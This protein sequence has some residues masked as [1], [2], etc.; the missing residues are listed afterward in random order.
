MRAASLVLATLLATHASA[1]VC[2]RPDPPLG[3]FPVTIEPAVEVFLSDNYRTYGTLIVPQASP[4]ACGWPLVVFVHPLGQTRAHEGV[5]QQLV[6]TQ[7]FA[8]WSFDVRGHGQALGVNTTHPNRGSTLW[9]P[10]E[11][12]DLVEQIDFVLGNPDWTGLVDPT[13]I[14]ITGSSQ[15]G[16]Q[17]WSAAAR[18]GQTIQVAG[19]PPR[20]MPAIACVIANDLVADP[21]DDW[22][23]DGVLFSTFFTNVIAGAYA[24]NGV[25]MDATFVLNG[26]T[27][28]LAQDP[29]SLLAGFALEGRTTKLGLASSAVPVLYTQSYHDFVSDPLAGLEVLQTMASPH[30]ALL[31]TGGHGTPANLAERSFRESLTL[32]WLNRFLWGMPNEVEFESPCVLAELPLTA[33]ERDDLTSAWSRA[34]LADPLQPPTTTRWFLQDDMQLSQV[35]PATP[36]VAGSIVQALDPLAVDF[37]PAGWLDLPA[38]RE[39]PN[40]LLACPLDER[41]YSFTTVEQ[42]RLEHSARLHLRLVPDRAEWMLAALLTVQPP[43]VGA[44]EV[45]LSSRAIASKTSTAMVAEDREFVLPPVAA[46]I[47]AGSIV[48]LRLRN[49]WLNEFPMVRQLMTVPLFHDFEVDVVHGDA[50]TGS[51]IEVPLLPVRPRLVSTTAAMDLGTLPAFALQL[52]GGV[53][54]AGFPY[55]LAVGMGG[56]LPASPYLG[57]WVPIEGDWLVGASLG[58]TQ[59]PYFAGFLGFLDDDGV[60]NAQVDFSSAAP[61]PG[62][63]AGLCLTAAGWVWDDEFAPTGAPTNALDVLLR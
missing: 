47:P 14:A 40:V 27:A 19:R 42:C 61:L 28:F 11:V 8:V 26:R 38:V 52:R 36:Q 24:A 31:G 57:E 33:T 54:R 5:L 39:L 55:V 18:S 49:L 16:G 56:Q 59:A 25:P 53:G 43:E 12:L 20:V 9:G 30:R 48:R 13:R 63:L 37:D 10:I 17:C 15:G 45:M 62:G 2:L 41:V 34:H 50:T 58:S 23:R 51:W 29:A 7:G 35:P 21:G 22:V 44:T 4:P 3:G 46:R 60:A 32:R 1:Q 6:A